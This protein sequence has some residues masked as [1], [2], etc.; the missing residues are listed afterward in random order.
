M[1]R[2]KIAAVLLQGGC[3]SAIDPTDNSIMVG[4]G[5]LVERDVRALYSAHTTTEA[6]LAWTI[7]V[8]AVTYISSLLSRTCNTGSPSEA[9]AAIEL[10]RAAW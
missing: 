3:R 9:W 10:S 4:D 6:T 2:R 5:G 8:D 7:V 1:W